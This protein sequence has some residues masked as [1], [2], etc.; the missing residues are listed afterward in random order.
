LIGQDGYCGPTLASLSQQFGLWPLIGK[1]VAV[2]SD[3]RLQ[4]S[5]TAALVER[6]LSISGEDTLNIDRKHLPHWIGKLFTRFMIL[7]NEV[8]SIA[9][10]SGAL[11][12]RFLVLTLT[13][14]FYGKEDTGLSG[15]LEK[16]LQG[17][18]N[19][20]L[21]GWD[22]LQRRGHFLQPPSSE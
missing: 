8:P 5:G 18:L 21:E 6:L 11:A 3:A 9:D 19:W 1:Q 10:T 15:T 4:G 16:E 7:T 13:T 2:V 12:G 20:A 17:I 14:N 22:R